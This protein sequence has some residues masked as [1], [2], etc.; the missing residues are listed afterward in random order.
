MIQ[1]A[2][3]LKNDLGVK[4]SYEHAPKR[5]ALGEVDRDKRLGV[6]VS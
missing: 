6:T 3:I 4:Q 2:A 5:V 1:I